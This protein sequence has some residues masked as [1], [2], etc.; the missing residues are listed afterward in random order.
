MAL[1]LKKLTEFANPAPC[2]YD[3][4]E[5]LTKPTSQRPINYYSSRTDFSK[6][7][8]GVRVGPGI[9]EI[10]KKERLS[11]G[12]IGKGD[13]FSKGKNYNVNMSLFSLVPVHTISQTESA[14][15]PNTAPALRS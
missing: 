13:K 3:P 6:S 12:K 5:D 4:K 11:Y 2:A 7:I 15:S 14:S 8:T 9:Y 1:K 10:R